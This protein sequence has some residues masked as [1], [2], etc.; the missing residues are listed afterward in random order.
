MRY[1]GN[2]ETG[3]SKKKKIKNELLMKLPFTNELRVSLGKLNIWELH[4]LKD[5][6][7]GLKRDVWMRRY[8]QAFIDN[9]VTEISAKQCVAA[10]T[11][12]DASRHFEGRSRRRC[13]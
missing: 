4:N 9:G 6:L 2:T 7:D 11:F 5:E 3:G 8:K 12:E 10:T 1:Y 13:G